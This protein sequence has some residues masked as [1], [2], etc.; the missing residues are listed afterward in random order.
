[1]IARRCLNQPDWLESNITNLCSH[2]SEQTQRM[3]FTEASSFSSP[4]I[5][6]I[7]F[8]A[9]FSLGLQEI[10]NGTSILET[11]RQWW[12]QI[13]NS[14]FNVFLVNAY[15]MMKV[16]HVFV[17][18]LVSL[19]QVPSAPAPSRVDGNQSAD[20]LETTHF[21]CSVCKGVL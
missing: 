7:S 18:C 16:N 13:V 9:I 8:V 11:L 20:I 21:C 12:S 2:I 5:R 10:L 4:H 1:M 3:C 6:Y 15:C 17:R 14:R 19:F